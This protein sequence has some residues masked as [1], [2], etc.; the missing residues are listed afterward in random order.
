MNQL[1]TFVALIMIF[2]FSFAAGF[3]AILYKTTPITFDSTIESFNRVYWPIFGQFS[4][5]DEI[6]SK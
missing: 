3:Q 6:K 4:I 2:V 5:L 1:G